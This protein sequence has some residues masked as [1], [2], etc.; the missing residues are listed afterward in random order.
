MHLLWERIKVS[1]RIEGSLPC[2]ERQWLMER[3]AAQR[4]VHVL[5]RQA[6]VV[7][8]CPRLE[9]WIAVVRGVHC[10]LNRPFQILDPNCSEMKCRSSFQKHWH[11]V[12]QICYQHNDLTSPTPSIN[13]CVHMP[14]QLF[15]CPRH[16]CFKRLL[17]KDAVLRPLSRSDAKDT[18]A[19]DA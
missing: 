9:F 12:L 18:I 2:M 16:C 10:K 19:S 7:M 6:E 3:H 15:R 17:L 14:P 5:A 8:I 1:I 4:L 13:D 11:S